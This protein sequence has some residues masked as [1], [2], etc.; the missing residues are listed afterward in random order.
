MSEQ[1]IRAD[2]EYIE[3]NR[4]VRDLTEAELDELER[5]YT[6]LDSICSDC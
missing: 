4:Q 3:I 5:L 1:D 2:I 6:L